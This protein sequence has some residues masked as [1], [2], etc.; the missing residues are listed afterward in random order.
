[1]LH[2]RW[3]TTSLVALLCLSGLAPQPRPHPARD[4]AEI[5]ALIARYGAAANARDLQAVMRCYARTDAVL[6]FDV[7]SE[8]VRGLAAVT[9]DW[10]RFI[11]AMRAIDL[12]FRDVEVTV[13]PS[14]D[15]AYATFIERAALT[16]Q[17]GAPI[18]IDNLR[19]THIFEKINGRWLIVH[20]HKSKS[21]TN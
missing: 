16:R 21:L 9:G 12:Q 18:V 17:Q 3:A 15:F 6:V 1:M 7:S 13:G 14:G 19:T 11:A 4:E 8:P 10:E 2:T 20:E 5:R